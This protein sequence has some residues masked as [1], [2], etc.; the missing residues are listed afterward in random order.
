MFNGSPIPNGGTLISKKVFKKI[1]YYNEEFTRAHDFEFW[2]RVA[3]SKKF[4]AKHVNKILY[5]YIIH[6]GNITGE[7]TVNTDFQFERKIYIELFKNTNLKDL[8]PDLNLT[9]DDKEA[10]FHAYHRISVK[11]FHIKGYK[12]AINYLKNVK[13]Y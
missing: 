2:T 7:L 8:F 9:D 4:K 11:F 1:G 12:E 10:L 5:K 3:L 6:E 13:K